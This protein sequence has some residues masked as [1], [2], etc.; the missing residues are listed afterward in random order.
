MNY[1]PHDNEILDLRRRLRAASGRLRRK[2]VEFEKSVEMPFTRESMKI[3]EFPG[4]TH[5]EYRTIEDDG[6][7]ILEFEVFWK[8]S[9]YFPP[10]YH[11]NTT[12]EFRVVEGHITL[13]IKGTDDPIDLYAGEVYVIPKGLRHAG[14]GHAGC[15]LAV[16][17]IPPISMVDLKDATIADEKT[18]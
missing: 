10:H 17:L 13:F 11:P 4:D 3:A 14:V 9:G 12:E 6:K 18:Y 2:S 16:K 1:D 8:K 7:R 15:R 5:T